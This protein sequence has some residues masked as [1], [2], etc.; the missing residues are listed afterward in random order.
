M[1]KLS[2][3]IKNSELSAAV[4]LLERGRKA[5]TRQEWEKGETQEAWNRAVGTFFAVLEIQLE[6]D[7]AQEAVAARRRDLVEART[8]ALREEA[9]L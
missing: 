6:C 1:P 7:K 8:E 2:K 5:M 4:D 3:Q 9:D